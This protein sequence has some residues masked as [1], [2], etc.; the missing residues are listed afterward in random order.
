M[1]VKR[2]GDLSGFLKDVRC[3]VVQSSTQVARR[4]LANGG[5]LA[6]SFASNVTSRRMLSRA[7]ATEPA[8]R[9]E[10]ATGGRRVPGALPGPEG[11]RLSRA[12]KTRGGASS[13][14]PGGMRNKRPRTVDSRTRR[15]VQRHAPAWRRWRGR[16][17]G[18]RQRRLYSDGA[19]KKG[20][21]RINSV[22]FLIM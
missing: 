13:S 22:I 17:A 15:G 4:E 14:T 1:C 8:A 10:L 12:W 19:P 2:Q 6:S 9:M 18:G 3:G 21:G 11:V 16:G 20:G 5:Y 7:M